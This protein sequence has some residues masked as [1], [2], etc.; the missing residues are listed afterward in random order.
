MGGEFQYCAVSKNWFSG[1]VKSNSGGWNW[2][3]TL[4]VTPVPSQSGTKPG[5]QEQEVR[6]IPNAN[7][8]RANYCWCDDS[9]SHDVLTC[10][11]LLPIALNTALVETTVATMS[12]AIVNIGWW[13]E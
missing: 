2:M 7:L 13:P 11:P 9:R 4:K 3:A 1:R 12:T 10:P 8:K 6:S 5:S